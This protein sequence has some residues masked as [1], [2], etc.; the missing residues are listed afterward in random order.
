MH[1]LYIFIYIFYLYYYFAFIIL[2]IIFDSIEY[3][4]VNTSE[5]KTTEFELYT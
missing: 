2:H 1:K 4:T 3:C 5:Q